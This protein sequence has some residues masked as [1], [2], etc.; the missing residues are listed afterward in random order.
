MSS[1]S[2][3]SSI[4][5]WFSTSL[6]RAL[7]DE[8]RRRCL[9][10]L[11]SGYYPSS[12][13]IGLSQRNFLEQVE[14]RFRC[15]VDDHSIKKPSGSLA[16]RG[17]PNGVAIANPEALPFGEKTHDLVILPHTLDF[18]HDP[19]EV[20]RQVDQVLNP[21]GYVVIIGFNLFSFYGLICGFYKSSGS[22]PWNGNYYSVRRVQDWLSLLGFDLV[23]AGM[24]SYGPPI[25]NPIYREKLAFMESAGD[26]WWPGLG[27]VYVIAGRKKEM[28]MNAVSSRGRRWRQLLPSIAK[29]AAQPAVQSANR[30]T[31]KSGVKLV[32]DNKPIG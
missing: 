32:V 17:N 5:D 20:L 8:E 9:K 6:G 1:L 19:H 16:R 21:E 10:L 25:Q 30:R 11:P 22:T 31:T 15:F 13:Q 23:G 24:M 3:Q 28:S 4:N 18:S 12:L 14:T 7:L 27:G 29:P 2:A 26:R